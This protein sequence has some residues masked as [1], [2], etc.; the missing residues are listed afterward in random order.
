MDEAVVKQ[1]L[2]FIILVDR[3]QESGLYFKSNG[4]LLVV[5][6]LDVYFTEIAL[7]EQ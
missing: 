3:V 5:I 7:A 2:Y 6:L 4:V 1:R